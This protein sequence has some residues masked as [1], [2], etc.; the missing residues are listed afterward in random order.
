MPACPDGHD[1]A[2]P[3]FCDV[4]GIRIGGPAASAP[5]SSAPPSSAP[6]SSSSSAASSSEGSL[7]GSSSSSAPPPSGPCPQ[8]GTAR[9]GRFCELCGFDSASGSTPRPIPATAEVVPPPT[10]A[11]ATPLT[12]ADP[13]A[14]AASTPTGWTAVVTADQAY[15]DSVVA[16]DGPDAGTLEFPAYCPERRFP[17]SG[18]EMRIGRRSVSR[19]LQPEIDLT[20]PPE[21]PGVS[22]L[23]AVLTPEPDGGW[24]VLDPGSS[25][26]TQINGS[27]IAAGM[28]VPLHSGDRICVGAWTVLTVEAGP[29]ANAPAS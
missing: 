12:T 3:D 23:H 14:S 2:D 6:S 26:G 1:S 13:A 27:A 4:C 10:P 20:G 17:L 9:A 7:P 22:H 28:R 18:Q 15:F 25:N 24:A 21:D 19:G 16:A 8:C 29:A 11:S 5:P